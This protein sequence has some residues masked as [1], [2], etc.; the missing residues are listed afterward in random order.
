MLIN[1]KKKYSLITFFFIVL[2]IK[3]ICYIDQLYSILI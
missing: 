3:L 2:K 1:M